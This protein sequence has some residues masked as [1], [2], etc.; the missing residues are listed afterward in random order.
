MYSQFFG[1]RS[2]PFSTAPPSNDYSY[3]PF[4]HRV[5]MRSL[6]KDLYKTRGLLLLSGA[7]GVGKSILARNVLENYDQDNGP[8][9]FRDLTPQIHLQLLES[10]YS[11]MILNSFSDV[12][13]NNKNSKNTIAFF[14]DS[15]DNLNH[16]FLKILL[17][18]VAESN[19]NDQPTVLILTAG[20]QFE[21]E[22]NVIKE[23]LSLPLASRTFVLKPFESHQVKNYIQHRLFAAGYSKEQLFSDKAIQ[24]ITQLSSGIPRIIN[25]ICS[26]SI[27]QA[28]S[29]QLELIDETAINHATEFLLLSNRAE[30]KKNLNL[31]ELDSE[32]KAFNYQLENEISVISQIQEENIKPEVQTKKVVK[33][34]VKKARTIKKLTK[35]DLSSNKLSIIASNLTDSSLSKQQNTNRKTSINK[36]ENAESAGVMTPKE[37]IV[38]SLFFKKM[39]DIIPLVCLF[40]FLIW[41]NP[42]SI[43]P[44]ELLS[45]NHSNILNDSVLNKAILVDKTEIEPEHPINKDSKRSYQ[46]NTLSGDGSKKDL[47]IQEEIIF[48]SVEA[49]NNIDQKYLMTD[50]GSMTDHLAYFYTGIVNKKASQQQFPSRV[51]DVMINILGYFNVINLTEKQVIDDL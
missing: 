4:S 24:L 28:G 39:T 34:G 33:T 26:L 15:F 3:L 1:L 40:L 6:N 18:K 44:D 47:A 21:K 45:K 38:K 19:L 31:D 30:I 12:C 48:L 10:R 2:N 16:G 42:E 46:S 20:I 50:E 11:A 13:L 5:I 32:I 17:N 37:N 41:I 51:D 27:F 14:L 29:S 36:E 25:N 9:V 7:V 8:V 43:D 22:L 35:I 23:S 49:A